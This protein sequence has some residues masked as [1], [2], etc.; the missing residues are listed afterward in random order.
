MT[1]MTE[2]E[3]DEAVIKLRQRIATRLADTLQGELSIAAAANIPEI[4]AMNAS[5]G[6]ITTVLGM[7]VASSITSLRKNVVAEDQHRIPSVEKILDGVRADA[8][9]T[10]MLAIAALEEE[11]A[12]ERELEGSA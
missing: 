3:F 4:V 7:N 8:Q 11:I 2:K 9:K 10:A 6:A 5:T 1:D 12:A